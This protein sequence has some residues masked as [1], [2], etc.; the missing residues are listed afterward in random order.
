MPRVKGR[1][2]AAGAR[3]NYVVLGNQINGWADILFSRSVGK[4]MPATATLLVVCRDCMRLERSCQYVLEHFL[5]RKFLTDNMTRGGLPEGTNF[6]E[7]YCT[8]TNK[9]RRMPSSK[10]SSFGPV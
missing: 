4:D 6:A 3:V 9:R 2:L 8:G 5:L 1:E 10:D 7:F